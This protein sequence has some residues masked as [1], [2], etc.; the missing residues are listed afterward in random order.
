[1]TE[2]T[3]RYRPMTPQEARAAGAG[4]I[5]DPNGDWVTYTDFKRA[6]MGWRVQLDKGVIVTVMNPEDTLKLNAYCQRVLGI[7]DT[8]PPTL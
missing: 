1:M 2:P 7:V 6:T 5:C 4:M 8:K 3:N